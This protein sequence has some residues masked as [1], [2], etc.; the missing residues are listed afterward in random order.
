MILVL[1]AHRLLAA[2]HLGSGEEAVVEAIHHD[3]AYIVMVNLVCLLLHLWLSLPSAGEASRGYLQGGLILDFV[4]QLPP[5]RKLH[6]VAHDVVIFILQ[7]VMVAVKRKRK[8]VTSTVVRASGHERAS[9]QSP[10]A[11]QDADAEERGIRRSDVSDDAH[12]TGHDDDNDDD[13]R[14]NSEDGLDQMWSGQ[15]S[16]GTFWILDIFKEKEA[17]GNAVMVGP[18]AALRSVVGIDLRRRGYGLNGPFRS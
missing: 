16:I 6:L 8:Q 15:G 4:G 5:S 18:S 9:A 7:L 3:V 1:R 10:T 12:G 14:C 2:S 13:E 17:L 11:R